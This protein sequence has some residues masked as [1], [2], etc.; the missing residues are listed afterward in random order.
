MLFMQ[1]MGNRVARNA[2]TDNGDFQSGSLSN[3]LTSMNLFGFTN[4]MRN[5]AQVPDQAKC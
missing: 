2:A 5:R 1:M 4:I 3:Q